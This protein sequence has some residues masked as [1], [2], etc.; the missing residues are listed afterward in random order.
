MRKK[1]KI[2]VLLLLLISLQNIS[3]RDAWK[4]NK[5]TKTNPKPPMNFHSENPR[6]LI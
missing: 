2:L 5:Q 1:K 4:E 6:S 3:N